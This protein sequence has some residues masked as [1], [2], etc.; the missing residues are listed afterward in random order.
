MATPAGQMKAPPK[1][2]Q[3]AARAAEEL[4]N[5]I[6]GIEP[7]EEESKSGTDEEIDAL[8]HAASDPSP[9]R[10]QE[11]ENVSQNGAPEGTPQ[12]AEGGA[13]T[14]Q[15]AQEE[16]EEE[17]RPREDWKQK[18]L[19]LKGKYDAEVPRL[20]EQV[21]DLQTQVQSVIASKQKEEE[22]KPVKADYKYVSEDE[23]ADYGPEFMDMIGRRAQEIAEAQFTPVISNLREEVT[24]LKGQL[25]DTG[26]R[27]QNTEKQ[28]FYAQLDRRVENWRKINTDSKFLE[29]LDTVIP[30]TD[31]ITRRE[32]LMKAFNAGDVEHVATFFDNYANTTSV[33]QENAQRKRTSVP[34]GAEQASTLSMDS[35]VSPTAGQ[36]S[37][38]SAPANNG[39]QKIWTQAEIAKF[40]RDSKDG[41]FKNRPADKAKIESAIVKA[42]REGRVR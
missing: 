37:P 30:E 12:P 17:S 21:R 6:R 8:L 5:K 22:A 7:S 13:G 14:G 16:K 3:A 18:Y 2:V 15:K 38:Q 34:A 4:Q 23:V 41:K 25:A 24:K 36:G 19:V 1:Q 10:T 9:E 27:V 35:L 26:Q 11:N 28:S 40:Y 33:P 31:G 39:S 32:M 42:V 20:S 29:W